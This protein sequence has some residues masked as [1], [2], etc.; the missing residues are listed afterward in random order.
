MVHDQVEP[1][2]QVLVLFQDGGGLALAMTSPQESVKTE[3]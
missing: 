2:L 3:A 1:R